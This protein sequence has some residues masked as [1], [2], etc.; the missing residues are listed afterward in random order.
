[1]K[2][3]LRWIIILG[4]L[5]GGGAAAYG[6]SVKYWK[7]RNRVRYREAEVSQG[8]ITAAVNSTGTIKPVQSV[9]I[10][11]SVSGPIM[12]CYVDFNDEVKKGDL[13]AKIDPQLYEASVAREKAFL[14]TR[15]AEVNQVKAKLQQA[16]NDE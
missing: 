15:K 3:L 7:E 10:G 5:I 11:A 14:A 2:R 8:K 1:M 12:A 6:P 16:K 13:L 9:M 4:I